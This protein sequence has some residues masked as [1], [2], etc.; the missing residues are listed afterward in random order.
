MADKP[1]DS[2]TRSPSRSNST[3]SVGGRDSLDTNQATTVGGASPKLPITSRI[4]G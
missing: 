2:L 1:G 4:F 3:N